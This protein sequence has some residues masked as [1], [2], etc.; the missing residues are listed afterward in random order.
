MPGDLVPGDLVPGDLAPGAQ[1][2]SALIRSALRSSLAGIDVD[3]AAAVEAAE[4]L[5]RCF[6]RGGKLLTFG[7]GGSAAC[8][9]HLAAEFVCRLSRVRAPLPALALTADTALLTA[10]AND[11]GYER[12]FARQVQALARPPDVVLAVSTS[13]HSPNV[14]AGV[15]AARQLGV[16]SVGLSG[17]GP[18]PLHEVCDITISAAGQAAARVQELHTVVQH[19]LCAAVETALF[20]GPRR[21]DGWRR[22]GSARRGVLSWDELTVQ[23]ARWRRRGHTVVW[24]DGVFD[25]V[26]AGQV[27]R[28]TSASEL[29]D[30]LVVGVRA[31]PSPVPAGCRAD[32]LAALRMVDH[33]VLLG[34]RSTERAVALLQPDVAYRLCG[35]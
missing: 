24:T 22:F 1:I 20:D 13:G 9:Q 15:D 18:S 28:L 27:A 26:D 16:E 7:N 30:V 5:A 31:G 8:A 29:G 14:L 2:R 25:P 12:V 21:P 6:A 33:A 19:A 32:V 3:V 17:A 23:R 4:L 34:G 35:T 11:F 10:I